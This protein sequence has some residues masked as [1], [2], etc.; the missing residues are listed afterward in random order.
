MLAALVILAP[1]AVIPPHKHPHEQVGMA[2]EGECSFTIAD[3]TRLVK[4]GDVWVIPGGV[5]HS[6][7]M[8]DAPGLVI[9][10]FSPAREDY[11]Y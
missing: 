10:M 9:E 7:V 6:V 3:E 4:P 1:H 8:G 2:L 11:K 5:E